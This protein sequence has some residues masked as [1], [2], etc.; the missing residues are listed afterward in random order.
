MMA[1][2]RL[3]AIAK[4]DSI[5][6]HYKNLEEIYCCFCKARQCM[7]NSFTDTSIVSCFK[8]KEANTAMVIIF[9]T[10]A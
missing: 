9:I 6:L 3:L 10:G 5:H 2:T 8:D 4:N 7:Y 1:L